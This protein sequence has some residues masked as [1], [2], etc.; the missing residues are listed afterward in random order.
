[1]ASEEK[2]WSYTVDQKDFDDFFSSEPDLNDSFAPVDYYAGKVRKA[3][4]QGNPEDATERFTSPEK[5][6]KHVNKE[7]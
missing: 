5:F 6:G 1:M 4:Q 7:S 2:N 3:C